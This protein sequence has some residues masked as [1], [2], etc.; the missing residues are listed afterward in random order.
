M[1]LAAE[2]TVTIHDVRVPDSSLARA[3]KHW[4]GIPSLH[5]CSTIRVASTTGARSPE[6]A[7][8]SDSIMSFSM[9]A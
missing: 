2:K 3:I 4:S 8:V 7:A 9:R 5:F 1:T 6:N